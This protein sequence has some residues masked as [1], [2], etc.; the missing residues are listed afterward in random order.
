[1]AGVNVASFTT[2]AFPSQFQFHVSVFLLCMVVL[3]GMGSLWCGWSAGTLLAWLILE[4]LATSAGWVKRTRAQVKAGELPFGIY[5]L[6]L[7]LMMLFRPVGLIPGGARAGDRE[8][9]RSRGGDK[10]V[11]HPRSRG[12]KGEVTMARRALF[13][14]ETA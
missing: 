5:G 10:S 14:T 12:S 2:A 8:R 6:I 7:V 3:G 1:M 11:Y 4:G 9:R 13:K